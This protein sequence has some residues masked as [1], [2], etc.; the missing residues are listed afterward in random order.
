MAV[1]G[2]VIP[3]ELESPAQ[4]LFETYWS[5]NQGYRARTFDQKFFARTRRFGVPVHRLGAG[6]NM[7]FRCSAFEKVGGFDERLDAGAAGCS[8]DSELWYRLLAAGFVCR[9]EPAAVVYHYH[10]DSMGAFRLLIHNYM[11]GHTAALLIQFE[12]HGDLG[13]LWRLMVTLPAF[14]I[15][16]ALFGWCGEWRERSQTIK[17]EIQGALAGVEYYFNS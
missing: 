16:L 10:R 5:F 3:A 13:N 9:Y 7:A 4:R 8:G 1:T 6:A 11:R 15:K 17:I 2:L 12:K 14:Y